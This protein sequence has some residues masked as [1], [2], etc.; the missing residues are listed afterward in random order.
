MNNTINVMRIICWGIV[1]VICV[2]ALVLALTVGS[3]IFFGRQIFS[4]FSSNIDVEDP[5]FPLVSS[6]K[7][8]E[9][10]SSVKLDWVRGSVKVYRS[11][12]NEV[13]IYQYADERI[14]D[15][16]I[17]VSNVSN[18]RLYIRLKSQ[19]NYFFFI[20]WPRA[21][22]LE[23][24]LPDNLYDSI[25]LSGVSN[26]L[27]VSGIKADILKI[28]TV[29]GR[30][31]LD[32]E[33]RAV[34][35]ETVSGGM[36][37][38]LKKNEDITCNSVSGRISLKG[39]Y[40]RVTAETVS[41]EF[42]LSSATPVSFVSSNSVSGRVQLDGAFTGRINSE[43][44]SGSVTV[45]SSAMPS[46]FSSNSV[47]GS[48]KLYI[49]ENNDGFTL[50]YSKVSGKFTSDFATTQSGSTYKYGNGKSIFKADTVSGSFTIGRYAG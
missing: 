19:R 39:E 29:S 17:F 8:S 46:S 40:D 14:D 25:D 3:S 27:T 44:V 9:S 37:C 2:G 33:A 15:R 26:S 4:F 11:A 10:V 30:V 16:D 7:Y 13:E 35:I 45:N 36:E 6:A 23:I 1:L 32:A 49:P 20:G 12:G 18:G 43:T 21:S 24:Y 5:N 47:S 22:R 38:V 28:D 34:S 41:G 50:N 48:V 42:I 31:Q